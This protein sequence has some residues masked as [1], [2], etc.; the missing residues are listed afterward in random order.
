MRDIIQSNRVY[1]FGEDELSLSDN[2]KFDF[3]NTNT[4]PQLFLNYLRNIM[5]NIIQKE[6]IIENEIWMIYNFIHFP[7]DSRVTITS[8]PQI[9][10]D[11]LQDKGT[12]RILYFRFRNC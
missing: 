11:H 10:Y 4:T 12:F 3:Q 8:C 9:I 2:S 7:A 1:S 6:V 5:G